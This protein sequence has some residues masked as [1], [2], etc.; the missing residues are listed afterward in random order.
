MVGCVG[1][2]GR[3]IRSVGLVR[4]GE[5][6]RGVRSLTWDMMHFLRVHLLYG[7]ETWIERIFD[8]HYSP[9]P[10]YTEATAA[11]GPS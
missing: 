6:V 3:I 9:P 11:L 5:E 2:T 1:R 7:S 8:K 10:N 4:G